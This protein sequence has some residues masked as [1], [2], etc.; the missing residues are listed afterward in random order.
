[1]GTQYAGSQTF[2]SDY[3]IPDDGDPEDAASVNV[4]LEALGDRTAFL[5]SRL[6][7]LANL[8]ALT[9]IAAPTDGL[10]RLVR[11]FGVFVFDS[12]A[13]ASIS[14]F[15]IAA[16]DATPGAWVSATAHQTAKNVLVHPANC[17]HIFVTQTYYTPAFNTGVFWPLL[18]DSTADL[19]RGGTGS[20][21]VQRVTTGASQAYAYRFPVN[22]FMIDGATLA[23][24]KMRFQGSPPSRGAN[25]PA[26]MPKFGIQRFDVD[27]NVTALLTT[28]S[29]LVT[30][31]SATV[32]AFISSHDVTFTP[33]EN[34]V[35]DKSLY[36][37]SLIFWNEGG[38]N[39]LNGD[40][41]YSF[42]FSFTN[43]PDARRS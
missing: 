22:Q 14:P 5:R 39:A 1:M 42:L 24:V 29:G 18:G 33:D 20:V 21:A 40:V 32:G 17:G 13:T 2:P 27:D 15:A 3:T 38:T 37:Y 25:L 6:D 23:S 10:V 4:A 11:G 43:I 34:N 19:S 26:V 31:P 7:A 41:I 8:A 30:D 36:G 28:G 12:A 35:I 9:A 16:G